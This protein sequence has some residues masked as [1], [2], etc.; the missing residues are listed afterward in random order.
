MFPDARNSLRQWSESAETKIPIPVAITLHNFI[1]PSLAITERPFSATENTSSNSDIHHTD[2]NESEESQSLPSSPSK[3]EDAARRDRGMWLNRQPQHNSNLLPRLN[4][5]ITVIQKDQQEKQDNGD[6]NDTSGLFSES[7]VVYS[8]PSSR[9]RSIHPSWEHLDERICI[10]EYNEWWNQNELYKSMKVK[11]WV[12]SESTNDEM[13]QQ[14]ERQHQPSEN[15]CFLETYLHPSFLERIDLGSANAKKAEDSDGDNL[16]PP[17]LPP[18]TMLVN[19]SDGS[20]RCPPHIY[21]VLWEKFGH[22]N[23][24]LEPPPV[25]DFSRF[26]DDVFATLDHVKQT[27]QRPRGRSIS[28]LLDRDDNFKNYYGQDENSND[29]GGI[30]K[31]LLLQDEQQSSQ[32]RKPVQDS[33]MRTSSQ[34][35][36]TTSK[37]Q[38]QP[39]EDDL[40]FRCCEQDIIEEE[41]RQEKLNLLRLIAEE[42]RALEEDLGCLKAEQETLINSMEEVQAVERDIS[43]LKTE[44]QKLSLK[45]E[46]EEF[47]K[48]AQSIKLFR[49]LRDVYP[50]TLGSVAT[51]GAAGTTTTIFGDNANCLIRGLRLPEDIYTTTIIEEEVNTSLGYCAHLVFMVAKYLTIQ[52]RHRIFCNGSRSAIE[53]D[54]VGI[55]PLFLGRLAARMLEREQVDRGARL[56]GANVNCIM[57]HLNLMPSSSSTSSSVQELHIL[58][59]LRAILDYVAEGKSSM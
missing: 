18:N 3:E 45:W 22:S 59:R 6:E 55:F 16:L 10:D 28:S 41:R 43:R 36:F 50:I 35:A 51:H 19:F 8:Q 47:L 25:E 39:N 44:L 29:G 9:T 14:Q 42:E 15:D 46:R 23:G 52:L 37:Q 58:R 53:L 57:M 32:R 27:P 56:L 4:L 49:D 38:Y 13:Q 24:I 21:R 26:E 33:Y 54:G 34:R 12:A 40:A 7:T 1:P 20:I 31:D 11:L 48:E 2:S 17:A 30:Q 5:E